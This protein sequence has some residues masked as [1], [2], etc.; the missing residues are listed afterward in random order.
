[1]AIRD[2]LQ[3]ARTLQAAW[4][5]LDSLQTQKVALVAQRDQVQT[6]IDS[7]QVL[8]DQAKVALKAV[9]YTHLTLPTNR[10]V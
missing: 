7:Q 8:V 10:E 4:D 2:V 9:S 6:Q 5:T 3:A 1:M